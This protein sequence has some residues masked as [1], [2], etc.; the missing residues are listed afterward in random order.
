MSKRF[1]A[2]VLS[3]TVCAFAMQAHA[4]AV[5]MSPEWAKAACDAWNADATLTGELTEWI[6]ND[7]GRGYKVMQLSRFDCKDS[8]RVEMRIENKDG[9]AM[10]VYGGAV[11]HKD[12]DSSADYEM[13]ATTQRWQ[14]MGAGEYGPMKAM[15]FGRLGFEGPRWEAMKNMGPFASFLLLVGKVE[16]DTSTCPQ[17]AAAPAAPAAPAPAP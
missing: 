8:P 13:R 14:E 10:C 7:K 3:V 15:M 12:L 4:A 16:S 2:T 17:A 6:K 9:K 11:E 5:M 1:Y